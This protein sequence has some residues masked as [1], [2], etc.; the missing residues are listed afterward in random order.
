MTVRLRWSTT[1]APA[2]VVKPSSMRGDTAILDDHGRRPTL[3]A[4]RIDNQTAGL[5]SIGFG[6]WLTV[7]AT[8]RRQ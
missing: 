1:V 8:R 6:S 2:G 5:D 7:A 4:G 3:R